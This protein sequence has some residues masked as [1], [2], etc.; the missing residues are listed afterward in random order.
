MPL[1]EIR[2]LSLARGGQRVLHDVSFSV[3]PGA[4]FMLIGPSGGGKSSLLRCMNRLEEPA[5]GT[6][7]FKGEDIT[8]LPVMTLRRRV[9]MVFQQ[10]AMLPGTVADNIAY[11][12]ALCD[13]TL[14]R[15][16]LVQLLDMVS[17]D[18]EIADKPA[19]ELSGG[20]AQRVAIARALANEPDVLLLDEPTSALDPIATRAVEETLI[21]LRDRFGL[22]L[23][24]VSHLVEQARRVGSC[25]MLLDE[26][27][28]TRIDRV[29][30][31]L[32]P[33]HGDARALAFA[34]GDQDGLRRNQADDDQYQ[35]EEERP[36]GCTE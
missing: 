28:I 33:E 30:V 11:G 27:R 35:G 32:S 21:G 16:R 31:M 24:W 23:V 26:G 7:F 29:D 22:T 12:P 36:H 2:H 10:T 15:E 3:N 34:K 17:L 19:H 18:G 25:V 20:Q 4:V 8:T 9:G 1:I 14:P 5:P 6:V 13:Q